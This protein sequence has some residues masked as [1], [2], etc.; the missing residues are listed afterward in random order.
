MIAST[1][2]TLKR[3]SPGAICNLQ[4]AICNRSRAR[5][6]YTLFE[7]VLVLAVLV[8]LAAVVYPSIDAMY[9]PYR[10]TAAA[11]M[12]RAG[13]ADART[14]AIRE[15]TPYRFAV[16]PGKGN[17]RLA[18]DTSDYWEG[19]NPPLAASDP[20]APPLVL[21]DVLPKGVRFTTPDLLQGGAVDRSGD[22]TLPPGSVSSGQ[23]STL[24]VFL[25]D[26]ASRDD[27]AIAFQARG[28]RPLVL[29]LRGLTGVVTLKPLR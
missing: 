21:E 18:P 23:W 22:T 10:L 8:V 29:R 16:V 5:A 3:S 14:H 26:G 17:Y 9:G 11:D 4:S 15:G 27:V 19:A 13:W 20:S 12:V 24:A 7:L 6:A 28:A 1:Q 2:T 25:P